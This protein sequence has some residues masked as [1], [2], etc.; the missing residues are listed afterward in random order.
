MTYILLANLYL[1]VFYIFYYLFLRKATFFRLNRYYLLSSLML[2][3][4]LPLANVPELGKSVEV[5]LT[6]I[7][8][9]F[10]T[11]YGQGEGSTA[12]TNPFSGEIQP[13]DP[14]ANQGHTFGVH[15]AKHPEHSEAGTLFSW[16]HWSA[17]IAFIQVYIIGCLIAFILFL[18]R[19]G[20]TIATIRSRKKQKAFSFF[21]LVCV[22]KEI[23]GYEDILRH[24][25]VHA[26]E[27]H[28]VDIM[29]VQVAKI[30]NWF[31]PFVYA[32]ERS[33][34]LQH[35]YQADRLAAEQNQVAYAELLLAT[36]MNV[37]VHSLSNQF[38]NPSLLKFRIMMLLKNKTPKKNLL[39]FAFLLPVV[40][41]M[42]AFSSACN[43]SN[44][45]TEEQESSLS[46][47]VESQST[48]S[49]P[50]AD[51]EQLTD[52]TDLNLPPPVEPPPPTQRPRA[53]RKDQ[54]KMPE[55]AVVPAPKKAV[56][57]TIRNGGNESVDVIFLYEEIEIR[58]KL[59][60]DPDQSLSG[61]RNWFIKNFNLPED[62]KNNLFKGKVTASFIV[63]ENGKVTNIDVLDDPGYGIAEAII[64]TLKKS[65]D[66]LS[67]IQN[68]EKV[69]TM[70]TLPLRFNA[71]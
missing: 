55:R 31:N 1:A 47:E 64:Q 43:S 36:A 66:W 60:N 34:K 62:A 46:N 23:E 6:Q 44:R 22:S 65:P 63:D 53:E 33:F 49:D 4:G 28:S 21:H 45:S 24:E 20:I 3:F 59:A 18:I 39:K 25:G 54:V 11:Q 67:G 40:L 58:P 19:F 5:S 68:G 48:A 14:L 10:V 70:V 29:L 56:E 37:P 69:R 71:P 17:P 32:M 35:E 52:S 57:D 13:T 50:I 26:N 51:E 7:S 41:G 8:A 12:A 42:V 16:Q 38:I 30:F 15:L 9:E 2:S 61:F 27:W